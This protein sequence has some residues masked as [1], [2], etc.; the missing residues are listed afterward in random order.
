MAFFKVKSWRT[1]QRWRKVHGMS[2][3]NMPNGKPFVFPYEV[4]EFLI[5]YDDI[6]KKGKASKR[7]P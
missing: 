4:M 7:H 5:A 1:I 6:V 3:R 2:M